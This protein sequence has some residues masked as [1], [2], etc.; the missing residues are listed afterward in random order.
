MILFLHY[1]DHLCWEMRSL[2]LYCLALWGGKIF[3]CATAVFLY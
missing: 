3:I 2:E 1:L